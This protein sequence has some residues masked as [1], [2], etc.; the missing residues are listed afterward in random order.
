[1]RKDEQRAIKWWEGEE[2]G[3]EITR[4]VR[5]RPVKGPLQAKNLRLKGAWDHV[6]RDRCRKLRTG[7]RV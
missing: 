5:V 2:G 1:M 4:S 7:T 3:K 6:N